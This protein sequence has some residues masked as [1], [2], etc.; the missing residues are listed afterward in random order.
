M[1]ETTR[2]VLGEVALWPNRKQNERQP[3]VTG[4]VVVNGSEYR[5]A[6]WKQSDTSG[7]KPSYKGQIFEL[8]RPEDVAHGRDQTET[9]PQDFDDD[10]PF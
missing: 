10:I 4:K 7:G 5:C 9:A 8:L 2:N 3:D 6:L 1:T